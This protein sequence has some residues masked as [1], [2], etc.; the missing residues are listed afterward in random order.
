MENLEDIVVPVL[1]ILGAGSLA[2]F[3]RFLYR[4]KFLRPDREFL[5][6]PEKF[7][8][9]TIELDG[10]V[11]RVFSDSITEYVKRW[12]THRW[13]T[14]RRDPNSVGRYIHQRF[15]LRSP[16]FPRGQKILIE[17]NIQSGEALF[18]WRG[19]RLRV[20]GEYLHTERR[21]PGALYGRIHKTHSRFGSIESI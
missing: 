18:L 3:Q 5:E 12:L 21:P 16:Y 17:H 2:L 8:H 1:G 6:H 19:R 14:Y 10:Y 11:E 9:R 20:R 7:D 4:R 15:L 13:R